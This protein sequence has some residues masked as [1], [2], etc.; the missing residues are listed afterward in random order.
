MRPHT[1]RRSALAALLATV[2]AACASTSTSTSPGGA[3][4]APSAA[5]DAPVLEPAAPRLP[6]R[7]P[8]ASDAAEFV[9]AAE[10]RL[11][12]L[13]VDAERAGWV[14]SNF[15]TDD[16]EIIASQALERALSANTA[17]AAEAAH[18][19]DVP[20][21]SADV[22]R[23]VRLLRTDMTMPAPADSALTA[24]LTRLASSLESRYGK[25]QWCPP[26]GA[27][28]TA[29][30]GGSDAP[31]GG[32]GPGSECKDLQELS[33]VIAESRDEPE[34]RAAWAGWRTISPPM[35][36]EYRRFVELMNRGAR[37]LG[38]ADAGDLWRAGYD[39]D[40][41]AFVAEVERLWAQVEPLYAQLHCHV[42][43]R[44]G[45]YYGHDLVPQDGPIPA[46][47][48]G[49]MWAQSWTNI[50]DLVAPEGPGI[51]YDLTS[52]LEENGYD[53]RAMVEQAESFFTSLGFAPLPETFWDRSLFTKPA[54]REV[55]CHAS[56]WDIDARD[57]VRIKMCIEVNAED[58]QTIHHELGHNFYQR[59]YKDQPY[60]YRRGANDGF[61]EAIGDAIALSVTPAY[62]V[63][64]GLLAEEPDASRDVGLLMRDALDKIAFLPFGLLVD[65]WRW[66]VF[67][68]EIPPERYNA[69]WWDLRERYQ[70]VAQPVAR[71]EEDFDP[72]AKYHIPANTPYTRYFLSTILQFQFHRALCR[73]AG[74]EGPLN[75]CTIYGSQEAGR[76]LAEM[77]ELGKSRPW[78]DALESLTGSRELDATAIVD[79]FA[80]LMEW[81]RAQ[82]ADRSCGW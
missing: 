49:N 21:M 4:A 9:A 37:E 51:G 18:Y 72:G 34:L 28:R 2:L 32:A 65:Q 66:R 29:S 77:L 53:A 10:A 42:R 67:S 38:F 12:P 80:P 55:V 33:R 69:G 73:A 79:Y 82:N 68:G 60:L 81:L 1:H 50:Y 8:T 70:G 54:D 31:G 24:E 64:I 7:P 14:Q 71:T 48:L 63:R 61:H 25:G 27:E 26:G 20:G 17:L 43:A 76:R 35:R 47:L 59:A 5:P 62:L 36:P 78:Q 74:Y 39:M 45:D 30:D 44:L 6:Q 19:A 16:T 23:K 40:S 13:A 15:I 52:L 11:A 41:E 3:P 46:H 58:F 57:D 56:A 75:R 22:A